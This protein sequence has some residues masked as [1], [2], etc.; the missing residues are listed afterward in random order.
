MAHS[1][2]HACPVTP[3]P[4]HVF[5][6]TKLHKFMITPEII[7]TACNN[8]FFE[9]KNEFLKYEKRTNIIKEDNIVVE[10][11]VSAAQ[12]ITTHMC[13]PKERDTLFWCFY[14]MVNGIEAYQHLPS[15]NIVVEKQL[16]IAYIDKFRENKTIIKTHRLAPLSHVENLLLNER[17]IDMKTFQALCVLEGVSC[18]FTFGKCYHEINIDA[19]ADADEE[20]DNIHT[21]VC[22]NAVNE[23]KKYTYKPATTMKDVHLVRNTLFHVDNLS[24]PIKAMASY[25]VDELVNMCNRLHIEV[26]PKLK[27]KEL[28]ERIVLCISG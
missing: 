28:Y 24:K 16:K 10:K 4:Q 12:D 25:K 1:S 26:E 15:R 20:S 23:N 8:H 6:V 11:D 5:D 22:N 27:K 3:N 7:S 18:I 19:S 17:C 21:I 9:T 13:S 2:K 14:I